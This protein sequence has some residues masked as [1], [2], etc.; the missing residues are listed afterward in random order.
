MS[1]Q[2][3]KM[4]IKMKYPFLPIKL[5]KMWKID[6][7]IL[8][9]YTCAKSCYPEV[10]LIIGNYWKQPKCPSVEKQVIPAQAAVKRM[11]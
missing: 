4:Q 6:K 10:L 5:A 7:S 1:K 11:L 3:K 8:K 9:K 2:I